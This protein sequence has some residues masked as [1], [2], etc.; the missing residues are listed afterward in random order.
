MLPR[1]SVVIP[2]FNEETR[3][4]ETLRVTIAYLAAN[5]AESELIVVNDGSTDGTG[6]IARKILSETNIATRLLENFPSRGKASAVAS[7]FLA[8]R[9]RMVVFSEPYLSAQIKK[10]PIGPRAAS[11][12]ERTAE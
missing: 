9:K 2:C 1:F 8:P 4:S 10:G 12:P 3:I 11:N 5:A 6:A 7:E